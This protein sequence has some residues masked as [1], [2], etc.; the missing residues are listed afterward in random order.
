[1]AA[2]VI[3]PAVPRFSAVFSQTDQ[4][5]RQGLEPRRSFFAH[6]DS[7]GGT[8]DGE[9]QWNFEQG[10]QQQVFENLDWI[11]NINQLRASNQRLSR[12][13]MMQH[14]GIP[15]TMASDT[16]PELGRLFQTPGNNGSG[17]Q[18]GIVTPQGRA[19]EA[20]VFPMNVGDTPRSGSAR[21]RDGF[22]IPPLPAVHYDQDDTTCPICH[23]VFHPGQRVS[24]LRCGHIFC[25]VCIN[26]A[27]R[28]WNGASYWVP[29]AINGMK[30]CGHRFRSYF[31]PASTLFT[32]D[33]WIQSTFAS[34]NYV[35]S[36]SIL[37]FLQIV[38]YSEFFSKFYSIF[39]NI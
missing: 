16:I 33:R 22:P 1:M 14:S 11:S 10:R 38:M 3:G 31:N 21:N 9:N 26:N 8:R 6:T 7:Q 23:E 39:Q 36:Q 32:H 13:Y 2:I 28:H 35:D 25:S 20:P 4:M 5:F 17:I 29:P 19:P 18:S 37:K 34:L 12:D 30:D 15:N 27:E 24:K